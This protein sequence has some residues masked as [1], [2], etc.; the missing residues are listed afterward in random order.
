MR[1]S[2]ILAGLALVG[3]AVVA[4]GALYVLGQEPAG[5]KTSI[6]FLQGGGHDWKGQFRVL[7]GI[8]TKTGDFTV[9]MTEDLNE[10]KA[11][12]IKKYDAVLFYG[13]GLDFQNADQEKGLCDFVREG[14]AF[15]GIHSASDSFKKSD[16]YW[17]LVGG[18]FAGHGG[19]KFT[20]YIHDADHPITAGLTDFE[21]QD[22]T[23]SHNYHKNACMRSLIRM[24]RDGERQSMGW[25]QTYGKGR[26]FYTSLGHGMEAW[27]NPAWQRLVVR[28]IY[29]SLGRPVKDPQ[30]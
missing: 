28:G 8:L 4:A 16:A 20:V 25:V 9:A 22:E 1:Y 3:L 29:W 26:V 27:K 15:V 2:K 21:I 11:E 7:E 19:G 17:E 18:R 14:H 30:P 24:N 23:Y 12:N 13:S 10:L 6:L 5:G